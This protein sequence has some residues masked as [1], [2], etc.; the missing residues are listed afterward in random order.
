MALTQHTVRSYDEDIK[1]ITRD[2][3]SMLDHVKS[4]IDMVVEAIQNPNSDYFSI[5]KEHDRKINE[6]DSKI[7]SRVVELLALRQPM[8]VDLRYIISALKVS[9][10]LER[11][12]DQAKNIVGKVGKMKTDNIDSN[13]T[14]LFFEMAQ[15]SK[16][17]IY[18]AVSSFNFQ[19]IEQAKVV[20]KEDEQVNADY[21]KFKKLIAE[22][23][24][25]R[26]EVIDLIDVLFMAKSFERLGDHA[27]N[28]AEIAQYVTTGESA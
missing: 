2:L 27:K 24:Y 23:D 9:V 12:G 20:L 7:E 8:A 1:L 14:D 15:M 11:V 5:I 28:I 21:R 19:N 3:D 10:N 17:M 16:S 6:I 4:S 13:F 26:D 25:S 22:S 18:N